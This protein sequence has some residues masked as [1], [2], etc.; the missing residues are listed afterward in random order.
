[1]ATKLYV[2][3]KSGTQEIADLGITITT[4]W[5]LLAASGPSDPEGNSGQFT[6]REIRDSK[7]LWNLITGDTIEWSQDGVTVEAAA[8]YLGDFMLFQDF[9]DDF[10]DARD[11]RLALPTGDA[12]PAS[13]VEGE[14]F[15]EGDEDKLWL[16]D[17]SQWITIASATSNDHGSLGGLGDDDHS[18]YAL[19]TGGLD[20]NIFSGGADFSTASGLIWPT[21]TDETGMATVEGNVYWDTDDDMPYWYDGSQWVSFQNLVSGVDPGPHTHAHADTTGQTPN[22]HHDQSHAHDGVDGSGQ[23][24]HHDLLGLSDDDH[25]QYALLSGD[26]ARNAF[27]GGADFST[28]SGLILPTGTDRTGLAEVEG[29]MMWDSDDDEPWFH[30]GTQWVPLATVISGL[31]PQVD[32]GALTGLDD[33]D[34]PQYTAWDHDETIS[35]VWTFATDATEPAFVITPDTDAPTTKLADGAIAIIDGLL[36]VYDGTRSKWLS[37][38]RTTFHGGRRGNATNIFLRGA[39]DDVPTNVSGYVMPRNGTITALF[40]GTES[41]ASWTFE[42]WVNGV[43]A[44]TLGIAAASSGQATN[45]NVDFSAGDVISLYCNGT[46]IPWPVG[47]CEVAWRE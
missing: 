43:Q 23:V 3:A 30:D 21:G 19:L 31:D 2:R 17:G 12:L 35:G 45:T 10:F 42:V 34:H 13:G 39:G 15:W 7:D 16:W 24:E 40:A 22:D 28:A 38:D 32:H 20:R 26:L 41:S 6:A 1:M 46:A 4:S 9:T 8:D 27:T 25:T 33:D 14:T 5:Y 29:N 18:Q 36:S 37:V 47:G 44:A 11:G